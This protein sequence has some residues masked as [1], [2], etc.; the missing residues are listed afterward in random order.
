MVI[1]QN[2]KKVEFLAEDN[3][4][5]TLPL[6]DAL[7]ESERTAANEIFLNQYP[8]CI[9]VEVKDTEIIVTL[10]EPDKTHK[11]LNFPKD[12]VTNLKKD[13][14]KKFNDRFSGDKL[15]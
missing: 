6:D 14:D 3:T 1:K 2:E 8:N 4:W 13:T 5:H 15:K 7:L 11:R 12:Q 10:E 9:S